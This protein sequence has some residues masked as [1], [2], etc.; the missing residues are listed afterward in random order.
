MCGILILKS[1]RINENTKNKFKSALDKLRSRGPDEIRMVENKNILIGFTRLS[2]NNISNGSQPFKSLCGRYF[3][4]FNGEIINYKILASDL[5][6]KKVKMKY[7]HEAEIILN[8]YILYGEKCLNSLR[9][10]FSFVI[11]E[12]KSSNIFA[13]VDRFSIKPLYYFEDKTENLFIL[14]SDYSALVGSRIVKKELNYNKLVDYFTLARY[15]DDESIIKNVKKLEAASALVQFGKYKKIYKYWS[16]FKKNERN[17]FINN[18]YLNTLHEKLL[19]IPDLWKIAE[20]KISLCL[21]TGLDS[22]VLNS[23]F[24][25]SK[26]TTSKFHLRETSNNFNLNNV[27]KIN[28]NKNKI[29]NLINEFTKKNFNPFVLAH[30]SSASLLQLYQQIRKN[31]FKFTINGEGSDELFGGYYRHLRQLHM[32]KS[33]KL[34]FDQSLIELYKKEIKSFSSNLKKGID[35][36]NNINNKLRKKISSIKLTS[37]TAEDK[38]LEFDQ[39]AWIPCLIQ[40]HDVIGMFFSLEVRPPYLDHELVEIAN[41]LPKELKFESLKR[42]IILTKIANTKLDLE[43]SSKKIGTPTGEDAFFKNK[44]EVK[45]FKESLFYGNL[46]NFFNAEKIIKT[47]KYNKNISKIFLWRLYILNKMESNF[48]ID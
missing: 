27:T 12:I 23:Y 25:K 37:K 42:K 19:E 31:K 36:I 22:Q 28:I 21:S 7:A 17:F 20:T 26:I 9:G 30:A 41:N 16:P 3:I 38:I 33:K 24:N 6:K 18:N 40:R 4:V 14:T 5:K 11:I 29:L 44:N 48:Q 47:I 45:N 39:I 35:D 13:A 15:L 10:F 43:I 46:S 34:N 2:I 1:D 32:I 8:L